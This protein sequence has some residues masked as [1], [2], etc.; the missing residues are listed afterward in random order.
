MEVTATPRPLQVVAMTRLLSGGD[1]PPASDD[2]VHYCRFL[3][4]LRHL[5]V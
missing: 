5:I 4:A 1:D 2:Q 3:P